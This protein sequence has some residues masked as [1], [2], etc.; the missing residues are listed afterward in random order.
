M[1]GRNT[2]EVQNFKIVIGK[3]DQCQN[4]R[5]RSE[6]G[7]VA[8]NFSVHN[9]TEGHSICLILPH[10]LPHNHCIKVIIRT[11]EFEEIKRMNFCVTS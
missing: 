6:K 3:E 2:S 9:I 5:E 1:C 7:N 11:L 4:M 8:R 10:V